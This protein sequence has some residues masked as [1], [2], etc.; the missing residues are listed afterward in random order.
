[1]VRVKIAT[2]LSKNSQGALQ[3]ADLL[4][5]SVH[6]RVLMGLIVCVYMR[7]GCS[8]GLTHTLHFLPGVFVSHHH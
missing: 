5:K 2:V 4:L 3:I 8:S 6:C 1:M 7:K